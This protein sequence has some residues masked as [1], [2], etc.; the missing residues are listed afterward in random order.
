MSIEASKYNEI[1]AKVGKN[2][3]KWFTGKKFWLHAW[4]LSYKNALREE[5]SF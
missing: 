2:A 3:I 4:Q 5:L 1:A